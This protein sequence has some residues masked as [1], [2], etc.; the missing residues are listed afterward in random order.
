MG[1]SQSVEQPTI[2]P[3]ETVEEPEPESEP[4]EED[5]PEQHEQF[6]WFLSWI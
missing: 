2:E 1:M 4:E 3:L 6:D 5:E